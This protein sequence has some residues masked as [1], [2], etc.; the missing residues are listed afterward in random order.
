MKRREFITLIGGA[1]AA[2]P[3]TVAAQQGVRLRRIGVFLFA[4]SDQMVISPFIKGLESLGYV[5]GKN[6]SIEYRDAGGN[7]ERFSEVAEELVRLNP[8]VIYSFGG[9]ISSAIKKATSTIPIVV[10]VSNDPVESGLVAS[11]GRPG[12]NITGLT[13]VHD[14][15]A[16]KSVELLRDV[17]PSI[18]RV[19]ILWNPDHADPEFRETQRASR[20]LGVQL[21]SLEVRQAGDFDGAFQAAEREKAEALIVIGSR[22]MALNRQRIEQFA[23][24]N[25]IILLG[26]PSWL[27]QMGALLSYGPN[28]PDLQRRIAT[29]VDKI[30]KGAK[31]SDLPMQQPVTFELIINT[32]IAKGIGITVPPTVIARADQIIE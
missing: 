25:K 30:L 20:T 26:V 17:A 19:A 31:P 32:S 9:D 1:A 13:Q 18:S 8:E 3:F 4:K 29:Y 7:S 14:M 11:L 24:K 21:Q 12:G 22:L 6:V 27:M 15:L 16:G 10:L 5:D 2:W 28:I 23:A